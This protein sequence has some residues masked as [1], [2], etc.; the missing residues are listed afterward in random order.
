MVEYALLVVLVA[1]VGMA[2]MGSVGQQLWMT[3]FDINTEL[4]QAGCE[5][6]MICQ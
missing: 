1:L 4:G 6:G 3:F 5:P 2:G